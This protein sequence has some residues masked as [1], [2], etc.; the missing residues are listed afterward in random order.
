M[1]VYTPRL[2]MLHSFSKPEEASV[3]ARRT[4]GAAAD[5]KMRTRISKLAC[6]AATCTVTVHGAA[7]ALRVGMGAHPHAT[8][9]LVSL[10]QR[11]SMSQWRGRASLRAGSAA[12]CG[13]SESAAASACPS[14]RNGALALTVALACRVAAYACWP[15]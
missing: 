6:A 3:H 9:G 15:Q 13:E 2:Q 1:A 8:G 11:G 4:A 14:G 5:W 10:A 12:R 7:A